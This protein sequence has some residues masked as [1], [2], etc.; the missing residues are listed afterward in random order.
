ME[1]MGNLSGCVN[2]RVSSEANHSALL[3]PYAD[4]WWWCGGPLFVTLPSTWSGTCALIQLAIPFT[5]AY[6]KPFSMDRQTRKKRE[7]GSFDP[8]IYIDSIRVPKGVPNEFKA[9]NHIVAGFESVLYW[10]STINKN[11]DWINYIYYNQQKIVNYT[12]DAVKDIAEQLDATSRMT[13]DMILA[14]KGVCLML[15]ASVV[16]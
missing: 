10:W 16:H 2:S 12:R 11:V 8:H 15:R 7:R 9:R 4:I 14:E 6:C 13:L 3:I 1:Y 5:L